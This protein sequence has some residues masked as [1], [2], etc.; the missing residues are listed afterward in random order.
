M[1]GD[2]QLQEGGQHV[3]FF[4]EGRIFGRGGLIAKW[5]GAAAD[6]KINYCNEGSGPIRPQFGPLTRSADE[7]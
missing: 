7:Y 1:S 3:L 4:A 6:E 5:D 2:L